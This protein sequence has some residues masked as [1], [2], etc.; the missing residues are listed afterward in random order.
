M[1]KV[2]GALLAL[3]LLCLTGCG[4]NTENTA[5]DEKNGFSY[6]VGNV[7]I[8]PGTDFSSALTAL[9]E[10][11][12]YT[13]AA[14]C[15]YDGMDKVYTYDGFEIRTYPVGEKDYVLDLCISSADYKAEGNVGVGSALSDVLAVYGEGYIL[16]GSS[17]YQYYE[18]EDAYTYFFILNDSVKY[19][20]YAVKAEN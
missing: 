9:G 15:Y 11:V 4:G 17:M 2:I 16:S 14:S 10:P 1:K 12:S 20:G 18:T 6:T 5:V 13:E 7:E 19:F 8:V 3:L